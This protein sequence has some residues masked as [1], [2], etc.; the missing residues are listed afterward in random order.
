MAWATRTGP[1]FESAFTPLE[2]KRPLQGSTWQRD[3]GPFGLQPA[4][5]W[6]KPLRGTAW[7]PKPP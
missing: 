7:S 4:P 1:F 5:S 2:F 6:E 3:Y